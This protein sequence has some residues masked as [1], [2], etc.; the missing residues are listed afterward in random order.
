MIAAKNVGGVV[1]AFG[2]LKKDRLKTYKNFI[3]KFEN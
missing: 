3:W 2:A 1:C